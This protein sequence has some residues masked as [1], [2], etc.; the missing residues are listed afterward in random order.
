MQHRF[1]VTLYALWELTRCISA[2]A[3]TL[4]MWTHLPTPFGFLQCSKQ[5]TT[6]P[7]PSDNCPMQ[8]ETSKRV[9]TEAI[10]K[11]NTV[12]L[13][14]LSHGPLNPDSR[15]GSNPGSTQMYVHTAIIAWRQYVGNP[16]VEKMAFNEA[17]LLFIFFWL[18]W[19]RLRLARARRRRIAAAQSIELAVVI[20]QW[21]L[22]SH[23]AISVALRLLQGLKEEPG[24]R[25]GVHRSIRTLCQ[26]GVT[27]I[28]KRIFAYV[29]LLLRIWW[30]S[31]NLFCRGQ[32]S[33]AVPLEQLH[34]TTRPKGPP[35]LRRSMSIRLSPFLT[36]L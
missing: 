25:Q 10:V 9:N 1:T 13:S 34:P 28:L 17:L 2:A 8:L 12:C 6:A 26:A 24:R 5:W 36:R 11:Y 31:C 32:S 7:H 30:T 4:P 21:R 18:R 29:A 35:L 23:V 15:S 14:P 27:P 16:V 20:A 3:N 19:R 33:Y 22:T